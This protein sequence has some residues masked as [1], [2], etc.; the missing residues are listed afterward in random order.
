MRNEKV[1]LKKQNNDSDKLF[2][3]MLREELMQLKGMKR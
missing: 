1:M 3:I 2:K